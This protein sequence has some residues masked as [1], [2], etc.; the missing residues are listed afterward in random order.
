MEYP[1]E[2]NTFLIKDDDTFEVYAIVKVDDMYNKK[3]V[4][5]TIQS[6]KRDNPYDWQIEFILDALQAKYNAEVDTNFKAI[7]L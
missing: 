5:A 3:D 1:V 6:V 2:M 4:E 7:Y